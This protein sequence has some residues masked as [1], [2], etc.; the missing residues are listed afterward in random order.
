MYDQI[1]LC[2]YVINFGWEVIAVP[3]SKLIVKGQNLGNLNS[4]GDVRYLYL[5]EIFF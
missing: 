2:E 1:H 4:F 5:L 3:V